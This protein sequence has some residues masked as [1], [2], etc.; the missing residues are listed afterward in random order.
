MRWCLEIECQVFLA[1]AQKVEGFFC[2]FAC[3]SCI[4]HETLK[5]L[6][7][8]IESS[9]ICEG[10]QPHSARCQWWAS[11]E[12]QESPPFSAPYSPPV[13]FLSQ[14]VPVGFVVCCGSRSGCFPPR[15]DLC[16]SSRWGTGSPVSPVAPNMWKWVSGKFTYS[17]WPTSVSSA[18]GVPVGQKQ[19]VSLPRPHAPCWG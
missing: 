5:K 8:R 13:S 10:G 4:Q 6:L 11:W 15:A 7:T 17:S 9:T 2:L 12:K 19:S 14:E 1:I 3:F 16:G 18:E